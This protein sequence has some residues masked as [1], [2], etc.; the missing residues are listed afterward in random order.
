MI[1]LYI[2][3]SKL[4]QQRVNYTMN[5]VFFLMSTISI[6]LLIIFAPSM[7]LPAMIDGATGSIKLTLS[8]LA[9]Y[10][11]W[12]SVIRIMELT[13]INKVINKLF[14]PI[15]KRLFPNTDNEAQ[16]LISLNFSA[17]LLGM[18]GC[19][20]PLGIKAI[21]KMDKTQSKTA[22]DDMILFIVINCTSI[23]LLPATIIGLRATAGSANASD[24]IIP[25]LIATLCS[26][27]VG[28]ILCKSISKFLNRKNKKVKL[29]K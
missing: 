15:T 3:Y 7:V 6:V 25:S 23:Q 18:G 29:P 13:G 24:I 27:V 19:A 28:I 21:E 12:L 14:R 4:N 5:I 22:T 17:N 9:V 1:L 20:T 2:F 16:E 26:T 8:L 10:C 11:V